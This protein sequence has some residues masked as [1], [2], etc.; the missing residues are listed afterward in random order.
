MSIRNRPAPPSRLLAL[1]L[2]LCPV[3]ALGAAQA[4]SSSSSGTRA[5]SKCGSP[6][7]LDSVKQAGVVRAG[8]RTDDPPHGFVDGKGNWVGFDVDI[9]NAVAKRLGVKLQRVKVDE[10]TRISYLQ[11]CKIDM[12]AASMSHTVKRD[13]QVDFSETYF[14]SS[15][16]FLVK[17]GAIRSLNDLAGKRVGGDRGSNAPGNWQSWLTRHGKR[18]NPQVVLFNDKQAAVQ[19]VEQGAIAG[20][21]EDYEI[22]ASFAKQH[23]DLEVLQNAPIG[24]KYDGLGVQEND[25]KWRD[26]IDYALQGIWS[27]GQYRRI[28][29]K[30][31]GAES[32]TPVPLQGQIEVWPQG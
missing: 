18:S 15:Q 20:Y 13:D 10:L 30:W 29:N 22:L 21:M 31:F 27:C 6:S 26:A 7:V 5:S 17:K 11:D 24:P 12:A 3:V 9:A 8:I 19:A 14:F 28:Y 1:V 4:S 32:A 2:L 16:T 25:S 23:P